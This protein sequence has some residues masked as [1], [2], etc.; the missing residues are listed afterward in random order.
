MSAKIIVALKE[1]IITWRYPPEHRLTEVSLC[2]EFGVSRSP[3]REALRVLT[4]NGF[5]RR[6]DNRGYAV[7][8]VK[9]K[10]LKELYDVRL[11]LELFA[12]EQLA[13]EGAAGKE[14]AGMARAWKD[15]RRRPPR[16]EGEL[17][18]LDAH[19]H[20]ELARMA[21]NGALLQQL[22]AINERLLIFRMIDFA[23]PDRVESTC[24]QHLL[25]LERI[26][27]G[28]V[29]GARQALRRNIEDGRNIVGISIKEALAR[30]YIGGDES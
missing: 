16:D 30:S 9:L 24:E 22:Q 18:K 20:E 27:A 25:V 21:G 28:D 23:K 4:T 19:F 13:S 17:A 3:V 7:R 6:M 15:L 26:A 11:A 5:V 1:R 12:V 29:Q 8:Q 2:R 14:L 10:E